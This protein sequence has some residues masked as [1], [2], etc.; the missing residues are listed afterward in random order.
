MPDSGAIIWTAIGGLIILLLAMIRYALTKGIDN[1][2][3]QLDKMWKYFDAN[4]AE[5]AQLKAE[6]AELKVEVR[7]L[8][9]SCNERH[10]NH[11]KESDK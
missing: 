1:I 7:E 10:A 9:A 2:L 4:I 5:H 11:K 8:R 3:A 6:H